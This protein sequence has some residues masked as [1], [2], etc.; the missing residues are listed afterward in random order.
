M[1]GRFGLFSE[2]DDLAEQFNFAPTVVR[3]IY[4][5][6][7][8]IPP[9]E[10]VLTIHAD[11]DNRSAR[12]MRWGL[13]PSWTRQP[14]GSRRPLFNARAETVSQRSSFRQAFATRRCL[15]PAN[16]FYE[17]RKDSSGGKTPVWFHH[18]G[19]TPIAFA[20]IWSAARDGDDVTESCAIITCA[21][22]ELVAPVHDR[23]PVI[24]NAEQ[25]G[26]WLD[27]EV[28]S[29]ALLQLLLPDDWPEITYYPVSTLVNRANND[30][31]ALVEPSQQEDPARP[32]MLIPE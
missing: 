29:E 5:P 16:G 31:P 14:S 22:N 1:C 26:L 28:S 8:N 4:R 6:R 21:A 3:D 20:G 18:E 13:M 23:M 19:K 27:N 17:W 11:D 7:W 30:S 15:L 9:T 2:L 25:Y 12:V 32:T 10:P 24:L